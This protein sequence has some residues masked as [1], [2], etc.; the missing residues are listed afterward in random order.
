MS[1]PLF[2]TSALHGSSRLS[3]LLL[4]EKARVSIADHTV[5]YC[6]YP[7]RFLWTDR[8]ISEVPQVTGTSKQKQVCRGTA[9]VDGQ[10]HTDA[11]PTDVP[12]SVRH[13]L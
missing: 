1:A 3:S 9:V 2:L 7:L 12:Q 10:K 6:M 13:P 11:M 8:T 5:C 4:R